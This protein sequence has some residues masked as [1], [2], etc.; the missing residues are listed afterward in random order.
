[1]K[2]TE[3][4]LRKNCIKECVVTDSLDSLQSLGFIITDNKFSQDLKTLRVISHR[5][6]KSHHNQQNIDF[7][8]TENDC[9]E[10]MAE[11]VYMI[12][13]LNVLGESALTMTVML[14]SS[15]QTEPLQVSKYDEI[16]FILFF[17]NFYFILLHAMWG[18]PCI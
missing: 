12:Q 9:F 2:C 10:N 6:N 3:H 11:I 14:K 18:A 17:H 1:M 15:A 5:S 16:C 4:A 8:G 13:M 7:E